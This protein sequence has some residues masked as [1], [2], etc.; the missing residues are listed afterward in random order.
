MAQNAAS[1]FREDDPLRL[2]LEADFTAI[3]RDNEEDPQY[4]PARLVVHFTSGD[5]VFEVSVKPRGH[6]RRENCGFPPIRIKFD[7][8]QIEGSVF[9]GQDKLKLVTP[10]QV[11]KEAFEQ[12]I[13]EEYLVYRAYN[14]L[15][16][17]SFQVRLAMITYKNT[18]RPTD[19]FSRYGFF[20]EP[21]EQM[22]ARL[23]A[24]MLDAKSVH[25]NQ[26]EARQVT[27]MSVFAYMVGNTD[28]SIPTQHNVRLLSFQ[29]G[30]APVTVPYDFDWSGIVDAPYA[31]PN[32]R[33]GITTVR[34]R[35]Y[36]GF[37]QPA[38]V[39]SWAFERFIRRKA[40]I[41]ALYQNFPSLSEESLRRTLTYLDEFYA[42]IEDPKKRERVLLS[43]CR[44][45]E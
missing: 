14:L 42:I 29:P 25:P 1:L 33:L 11:G 41:Y 23:G 26:T 15:T 18:T 5:E 8:A 30:T 7:E 31:R 12:Y 43:T 9:E 3:R 37:C 32:E 44:S 36:R 38:E 2:T 13:L 40:A 28:W 16:D 24:K 35:V 21:E 4:R 17:T 6:F 22:A 34:D 39:T 10:C 19:T 20:I 27:L 45:A